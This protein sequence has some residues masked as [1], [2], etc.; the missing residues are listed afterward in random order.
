LARAVEKC[1][2]AYMQEH[3]ANF[4]MHPPH[5]LQTNAALFVRGSADRHHDVP[6]DA[7]QRILDW[8]AAELAGSGVPVAQAY[9]DLAPAAAGDRA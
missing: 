2:F 8:A 3:Q 6:A 1:S 4:E 7:R 9:Q 5:L